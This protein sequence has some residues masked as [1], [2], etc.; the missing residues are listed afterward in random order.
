M[1]I[2][3][4]HPII[5]QRKEQIANYDAVIAYREAAA[6]KSDFERTEMNK[7]KTGVRLEGITRHQPGHRQADSR[8]GVRLCAH[9]LRHRRD[10]GRAR[11]RRARL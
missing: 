3:P 10:H 8:V 1:V 4:E 11:P 7:D 2:S 6:R 5:E 9:E